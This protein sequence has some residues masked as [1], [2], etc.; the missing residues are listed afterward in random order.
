[1]K[2]LIIL[3]MLVSS[4]FPQEPVKI[5]LFIPNEDWAKVCHAITRMMGPPIMQGTETSGGCVN[6][7][8]GL[9]CFHTATRG[10]G[11]IQAKLLD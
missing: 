6:S 11:G 5:K 4:A 2:N 1:M 9:R 8:M 7:R 10:A 3:L